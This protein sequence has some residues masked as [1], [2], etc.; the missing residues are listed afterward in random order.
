MIP[1]SI[2]WIKDPTGRFPE[3]PY[4]SQEDLDCLSEEWMVG[5]LIEMYGKAEF[6]VSTEDLKVMIES[7]SSDL[8]QYADL[9]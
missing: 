1:S 5:F 4:V 3:R 7:E 6:P 8:D 9:R 2:R